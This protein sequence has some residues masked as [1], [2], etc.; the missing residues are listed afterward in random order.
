[1][2]NTFYTS[3]LHCSHANIILYCNRPWIDEENDIIPCDVRGRKWVSK[4]IA[5]KRA[6]EMDEVLVENWN[7][8]IGPDDTVWYLGDF[9]MANN[10]GKIDAMLSKLNG[11]KHLILG[12]HDPKK[13]ARASGW[14]SVRKS[15]ITFIDGQ[16]VLM[17]HVKKYPFS[18]DWMLHGHS[19]KVTNIM[20]GQGGRAIDIG[21]DGHNYMPYSEEEIILL[22]RKNNH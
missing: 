5:M 18:Q 8:V 3:D 1:M 12:N 13:S 4:D 2:S 14:E 16:S 11:H 19:H 6:A 7:S 21:V 10:I 9:M 17:E 15:L 22:M 20:S